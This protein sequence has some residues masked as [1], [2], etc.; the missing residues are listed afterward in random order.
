MTARRSVL[1]Q[2]LA[3]A[4]VVGMSLLA[5][6]LM[7]Y[8]IPVHWGLDGRPDAWGSPTFALAFG[9]LCE[10][11]I[12]A[13]TIALVRGRSAPPTGI[14]AALALTAALFLGGH[15]LLLGAT[16]KGL[17]SIRLMLTMTFGLF[18]GI[19]PIMARVEQN[20]WFGVR[21]P[22]TLGSRR[23]W[24]ETHRA[25]GRLWL[26]GGALGSALTLFGA[27]LLIVVAY[28]AVLALAPAA[29]SYRVW[30]RL[31]RP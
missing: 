30:R 28:L 3:I 5:L 20:P 18:F 22:W 29:I 23:V 17:F 16:I 25:T 24:K 1:I 9:P 4:L 12:L 10:F 2:I 13:L 27:P 8:E 6:P 11:G 19:A 21:T 15:A 14:F 31:G 26:L 7:R